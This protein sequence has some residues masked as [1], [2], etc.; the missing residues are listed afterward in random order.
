MKKIG[1][2]QP[3]QYLPQSLGTNKD[4]FDIIINGE[5]TGINLK[6]FTTREWFIREVYNRAY[7]LTQIPYP[8]YDA[9][10]FI[11]GDRVGER[12][13]VFHTERHS[14][15]RSHLRYALVDVIQNSK[16]RSQLLS[17]VIRFYEHQ[18][19]NQNLR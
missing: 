6:V 2:Y 3:I 17:S 19:I 1:H 5:K 12:R 16:P 11:E 18:I 9:H 15:S 14:L 10:H 4:N 7:E 13:I 8:D